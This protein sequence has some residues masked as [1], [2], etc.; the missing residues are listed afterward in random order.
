MA[1]DIGSDGWTKPQ[2]W[3]E[4]MEFHPRLTVS[5]RTYGGF[6]PLFDVKSGSVHP[7]NIG[8][9]KDEWGYRHVELPANTSLVTFFGPAK[10]LVRFDG[11]VVIPALYRERPWK[12]WMSHT[13]MEVFSQR[14]G[15]AW[16]SGTVL[17]GGFGMGWALRRI[18]EKSSVKRVIC[19]EKSKPLIDWFAGEIC[20]SMPKVE[21][22][23]GDVYDHIGK[24]GDDVKHVLDIWESYRESQMDF[25]LI[26]LISEMPDIKIWCWGGSPKAD[27]A[28]LR[29]ALRKMP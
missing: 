18:A 22:I 19:I 9:V 13:P 14:A 11:D 15:I 28:K 24:H 10:G 7:S 20:R 16:A 26:S 5:A 2:P 12:V 27:A 6:S 4:S 8:V 23:H 25:R 3:S 1:Y 17:V 21:L 29:S